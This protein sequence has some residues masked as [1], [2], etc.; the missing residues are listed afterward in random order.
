MKDAFI[1]ILLIFL[2]V[3]LYL[4]VYIFAIIG[5]VGLAAIFLWAA[6]KELNKEYKP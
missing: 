1:V 5:G 2:I 3:G 4:A 6:I